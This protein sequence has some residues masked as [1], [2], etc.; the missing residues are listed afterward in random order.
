MGVG[1]VCILVYKS[2]VIYNMLRCV[3]FVAFCGVC[4][5]EIVE[6]YLYLDYLV[7]LETVKKASAI[8]K[9][10]TITLSFLLVSSF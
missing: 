5:V 4:C 1:I 9:M 7:M 3:W 10:S 6:M 2:I 8:C